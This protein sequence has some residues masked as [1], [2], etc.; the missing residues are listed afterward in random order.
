MYIRVV[1]VKKWAGREEHQHFFEEWPAVVQ[2]RTEYPLQGLAEL[3]VNVRNTGRALIAEIAGK[4]HV[5]AV[6]ARCL[7]SFDL[8]I[9]FSTVEEFR[10]EPGASDPDQDY[11]RFQGDKIFLDDIVADAFGVSVPYAPYCRPDCQ[12]LCPHCGA[13]LNVETCNCQEPHDSRWSLL[14]QLKFPD[15]PSS[16]DH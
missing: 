3:D 2:E 5:Q 13:N 4:A 11:Y 1:D 6:C 14:E 16:S 8:V 9:P 12:G 10:E 15:D 7:E